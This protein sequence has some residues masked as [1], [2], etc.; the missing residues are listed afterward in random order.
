M[1]LFSSP[2][3]Y[4]SLL[5]CFYFCPPQICK[6]CSFVVEMSNDSMHLSQTSFFFQSIDFY[7]ILPIYNSQRII[8]KNKRVLLQTKKMVQVGPF[9]TEFCISIPLPT[10]RFPEKNR[11][12]G[13]VLHILSIFSPQW[14]DHQTKQTKDET[15]LLDETVT[16]SA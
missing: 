10:T 3:Y 1:C 15:K 2:A 8:S 4:S 12:F 9:S 7:T 13:T 16:H 6:M 5:F 14:C 11:P